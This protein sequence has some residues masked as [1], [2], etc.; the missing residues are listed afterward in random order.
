MLAVFGPVA[1]V[2]LVDRVVAVLLAPHEAERAQLL[3]DALARALELILHIAFERVV[4]LLGAAD[5]CLAE[6]DAQ[7]RLDGAVQLERG[8]IGIEEAFGLEPVLVV[9]AFL[10]VEVLLQKQVVAHHVGQGKRQALGIDALEHL[11]GVERAVGVHDQ[12]E[13]P[14]HP[15]PEA[16]RVERGIRHPLLE[17]R[18]VAHDALGGMEGKLAAEQLSAQRGVVLT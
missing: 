1:G 15:V 16:A 13:Q 9:E 2:E 14:P 4:H 5:A 17:V 7:P 10:L 12:D 11:L 18:Q 6:P 3:E 8:G